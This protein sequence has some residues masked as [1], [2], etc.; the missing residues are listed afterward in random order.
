VAQL[1]SDFASYNTLTLALDTDYDYRGLRREL[2]GF[3]GPA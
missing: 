1:V 2:A 3:A